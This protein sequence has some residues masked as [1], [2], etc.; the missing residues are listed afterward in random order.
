MLLH[1][2]FLQYIVLLEVY[3]QIQP[4]TYMSLEKEDVF[5]VA[6]T[7]KLSSSFLQLSCAVVTRL[8]Y[9]KN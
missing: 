6:P 4:Q 5:L 9:N 1:L 2:V 3:E 8:V 7:P